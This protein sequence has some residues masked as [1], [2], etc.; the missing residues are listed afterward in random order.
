MLSAIAARKAAQASHIGA[1]K[2]VVQAMEEESEPSSEHEEVVSFGKKRSKT[3][4]CL[5]SSGAKKKKPRYFAERQELQ[6]DVG[7][8]PSTRDDEELGFDAPVRC[9]WSPS[10]PLRDSSDEEPMDE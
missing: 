9:A 4:I 5:A 2:T 10:V 8:E 1:T 7:S 6:K 3:K